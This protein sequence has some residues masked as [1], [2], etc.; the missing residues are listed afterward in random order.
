MTAG[1]AQMRDPSARGDKRPRLSKM[2]ISNGLKELCNEGFPEKKAGKLSLS[3]NAKLLG[4]S[5]KPNFSA[6]SPSTLP[7]EKHLLRMNSDNLPNW[8]A[9][10]NEEKESG[11]VGPESIA[12]FFKS[13]S[14]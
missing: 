9:S 1:G 4:R 3:S 5:K 2:L 8:I 10:E 12:L 11:E 7:V 6:S 14:T 13:V